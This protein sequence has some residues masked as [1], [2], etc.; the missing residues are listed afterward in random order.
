MGLAPDKEMK[1]SSPGGHLGGSCCI[2]REKGEK[3]TGGR[4]KLSTSCLS[5]SPR[6]LQPTQ[7]GGPRLAPAARGGVRLASRPGDWAGA[8]DWR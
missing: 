5:P 4:T 7:C 8:G 1:L 6:S 3:E 2:N